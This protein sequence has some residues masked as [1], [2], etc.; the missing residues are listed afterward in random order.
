MPLQRHTWKTVAA[1]IELL[2][3]KQ[4]T[5]DL[6]HEKIRMSHDYKGTFASKSDLEM[7]RSRTC[8]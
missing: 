8:I 7:L 5:A 2:I 3:P 1:G 6:K 4:P